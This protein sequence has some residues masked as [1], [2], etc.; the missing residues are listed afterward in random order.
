MPLTTDVIKFGS[1]VV[2]SQVRRFSHAIGPDINK[3]TPSAHD[4]LLLGSPIQ[5]NR[6]LTSH[7]Y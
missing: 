4:V 1:F 7:L 6:N 2:T 3:S 5:Q